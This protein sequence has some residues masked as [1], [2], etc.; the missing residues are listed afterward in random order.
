LD[1][2]QVDFGGYRAHLQGYGATTVGGSG[3]HLA[4][5]ATTVIKVTNTN[6]FG[7][8][9]FHACVTASGPRVCVFETSGLITLTSPLDITNP[10]LTIAGQTAPSPGVTINARCGIRVEANDVVIQ[11]IRIRR[12]DY[13]TCG[14]LDAIWVRNNA[15]NVVFD[16][17]SASWGA[18]GTLDFNAASGADPQ[19]IGVF[20][21]IISETLQESINPQG[22]HARAMLFALSANGTVT[23]ARNLLAHHDERYPSVQAG[24]RVQRINNLAYNWVTFSAKEGPIA[25]SNGSTNGPYQSNTTHEIVE[26]GNIH[27]PGLD[28][29]ANNRAWRIQNLYPGSTVYMADNVSPL[30]TGPTGDGQ[31]AGVW[32]SG[33]VTFEEDYRVDSAPS[34]HTA[35]NITPLSTSGDDGTSSGTSAARTYVLANAGARPTDRDSHDTRVIASVTHGTGNILDSQADIGTLTAN[36]RDIDAA[37]ALI[38]QDDDGDCGTTSQGKARTEL[39]CFL[40][41][42]A[43]FGAASVEP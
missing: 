6:D 37:L 4:T 23:L 28:T 10:Y 16:H 29:P 9:S 39:E 24:W 13:S 7:A 17:V 34:W 21:S 19:D 14:D 31:W 38:T 30:I 26:L 8:G 43:T 20:D 35:F 2:Q 40:E 22:R 36:T 5:T 41:N 3:R 32:N 12:G 33:A 18:D 15:F 25:Y 42:D 1:A 27:I 11:H